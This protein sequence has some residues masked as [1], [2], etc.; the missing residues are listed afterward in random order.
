MTWRERLHYLLLGA[1]SLVPGGARPHIRT[2]EELRRD[3]EATYD[4][5]NERPTP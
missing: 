5:L 2:A 3:A 1:A 4:A